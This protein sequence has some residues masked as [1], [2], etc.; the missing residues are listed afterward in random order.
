M[1]M[2]WGIGGF[3]EMES[4]IFRVLRRLFGMMSVGRNTLLLGTW[5]G[6]SDPP[7]SQINPK[8]T[9]VQFSTQK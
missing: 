4:A 7:P 9:F 1:A 2:G 5:K 6:H 8:L 3:S